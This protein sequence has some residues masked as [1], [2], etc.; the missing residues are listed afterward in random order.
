MS[1]LR[2]LLAVTLNCQKSQ[3]NQSQKKLANLGRRVP[4]SSD[5]LKLFRFPFALPI[6]LSLTGNAVH[7]NSGGAGQVGAGC[8]TS[9]AGRAHAKVASAGDRGND[10]LRM[11]KSG[12][13]Q[14]RRYCDRESSQYGHSHSVYDIGASFGRFDLPG[15]GVTVV[16]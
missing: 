14:Q 1:R 10:S 12:S 3:S 9:V 4:I 15:G 8:R 5:D 2:I 6:P 16:A 7:G 13:R 11:D